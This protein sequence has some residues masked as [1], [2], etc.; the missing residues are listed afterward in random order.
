MSINYVDQAPTP[1]TTTPRRH[2][3]DLVAH[4][5]SRASGDELSSPGG[6]ADSFSSVTPM[7]KWT[8]IDPY[9]ISVQNVARWF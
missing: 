8:K 9:T 5:P 7:T 3:L 4:V 2:L 6:I 1:L